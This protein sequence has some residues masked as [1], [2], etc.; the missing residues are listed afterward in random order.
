MF[1][2]QKEIPIEWFP[3][4]KLSGSQTGGQIQRI[5]EPKITWEE[6]GPG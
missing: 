3:G 4:V 2:R 6:K 5:Y 1:R